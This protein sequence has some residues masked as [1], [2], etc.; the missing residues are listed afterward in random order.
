[1]AGLVN[2]WKPFTTQGVPV[3]ALRDNP[4]GDDPEQNPNFCLA[5]VAPAEANKKCSFSRYERLD[6]WYNAYGDA[7]RQTP[8][9]T[10]IDLSHF[11]CNKWKCPVVIGGVNVYADNNHLSV[12][13]A[14][15]LGPY[16]LRAMADEGVDLR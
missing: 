10:E 5:E 3:F 7:A 9:A 8:G 1:V 4:T 13:Y 16:L 12:T 15:T 14:K 6:R 11:Y 2:A